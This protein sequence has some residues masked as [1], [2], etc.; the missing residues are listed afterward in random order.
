MIEKACIND[1]KE[2]L[3]VINTSNHDAFKEIIPQEYFRSPV[4]SLEDLLK[5]FE[6]MIFY[7]SKS[8]SR[9]IGVA[10]LQIET[11]ET[12]RIHWV[13]ILPRHQRKGIGT[14]L[15]THL[16]CKARENGLRKLRLLTIE[17]AY[18]AVNFYKKLGYDLTEKIKRPW[19]FDIIME[20]NL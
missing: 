14:A 18:W 10:A 20:K 4:L 12:G 1:T 17:K 11:R 7:V 9:I 8:E 19:G 15:L 13:Y 3:L 5:D 6:K 16:E 2:I